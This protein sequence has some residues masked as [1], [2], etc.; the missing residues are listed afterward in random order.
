MIDGAM[1]ANNPTIAAIVEAYHLYYSTDLT[2]LDFLIV[3]L[4]T[5]S[6]ALKIDARGAAS[7][8]DVFWASPIISILMDGSSQT[9]EIEVQELF[10]GDRYTRLD[11]SLATVTPQNEIVDPAMDNASPG[12]I[13]ALQAKAQQL[14]DTHKKQIQ[15]LAVELAKPKDALRP[16][17]KPPAKS[18]MDE[19]RRR[20]GS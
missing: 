20:E 17:P 1:F 15:S 8:G 6:V 10:G 3:S 7:W 14:I 11:I 12:N 18:F 16:Q 9:V 2:D 4:G 13:K 19:L 5:G